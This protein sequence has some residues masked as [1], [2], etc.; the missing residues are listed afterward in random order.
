MTAT[1]ATTDTI[2]KLVLSTAKSYADVF[3]AVQETKAAPVV[4][5]TTPVAKPLVLT[6]AETKALASFGK[7][8]A[9]IS[10][11][12]THRMM[13]T[14]EL[15]NANAFLATAKVVAAVAKRATEKTLRPAFMNHFDEAARKSGKVTE[16]TLR[17]KDG[18]LVISDTE[19]ARIEGEKTYAAREARMGKV[20]ITA[21]SIKALV[22]SGDLTHAQYL[23]ATSQV[24]VADE[25]AILRM[26]QKNSALAE[27]FAKATT[28]SQPSVAF[29]IK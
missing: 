22:D 10:V 7:Q 21:D 5:A 23:E 27:V 29:T 19:S 24:R 3:K 12:Q 28:M 25:D 2:G 4:V 11:P 17:D 6:E 8:A 26:V 18:Y 13:S 9:A 14:A 1:I 16:D 20:S 15:T